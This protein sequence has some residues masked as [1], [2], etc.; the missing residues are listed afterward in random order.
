MSNI[1]SINGGRSPQGRG[2][3][4]NAQTPKSTYR[5]TDDGTSERPPAGAVQKGRSPAKSLRRG[6]PKPGSA[7]QGAR[8]A[9]ASPKKRVERSSEADYR[10]YPYHDEAAIDYLRNYKTSEGARPLRD[11]TAAN[12]GN[13]HVEDNH[14]NVDSLLGSVRDGTFL[15]GGP[16]A[17]KERSVTSG[18]DQVGR[19]LDYETEHLSAPETQKMW[20]ELD[21]RTPPGIYRSLKIDSGGPSGDGI[22]MNLDNQKSVRPFL[23]D[24]PLALRDRITNDLVAP[25]GSRSLYENMQKRSIPIDDYFK[26]ANIVADGLSGK[27][28]V[29]HLNVRGYKS[30]STYVFH[31]GNR[32][33]MYDL[34]KG[35]LVP[36]ANV[37]DLRREI[38]G[39]QT[40]HFLNND[41][42]GPK[43]YLREGFSNYN[44]LKGESHQG[45][46]YHLRQ[47]NPH[48]TFRRED[49]IMYGG[50]DSGW[51]TVEPGDFYKD[52]TL[53]LLDKNVENDTYWDRNESDYDN[54]SVSRF[55]VGI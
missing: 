26:Y 18:H 27:G 41:F 19:G 45:V 14:G 50:L 46:D 31:D 40:Q 30:S 25:A 10:P 39:E 15:P 11:V 21:S 32:G 33:V 48:S 55:N 29:E 51:G 5:W 24:F 23:H 38:A 47:F 37:Q 16:K 34:I 43:N 1:A 6:G 4:T 53:S 36:F 2:A 8:V 17:G 28:S 13:Y 3:E 44:L 49:D 22:K 54:I 9:E 42:Y 7:P 20:D 52:A 12:I 35:E